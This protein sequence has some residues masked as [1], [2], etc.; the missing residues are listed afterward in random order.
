M[1][2]RS[3][4]WQIQSSFFLFL[5]W[6]GPK[7]F[8]MKSFLFARAPKKSTK[9]F[10]FF[11]RG[12]GGIEKFSR[13][14]KTFLICFVLTSNSS[15]KK[16]PHFLIFREGERGNK[17]FNIFQFGLFI[18]L[19]VFLGGEGGGRRRIQKS[20]FLITFSFCSHV[21]KFSVF[22]HFFHCFWREEEFKFLKWK[23]FLLLTHPK[24]SQHFPFFWER[25]VGKGEESE[26]FQD[27]WLFILFSRPTVQ[28]KKPFFTFFSIKERRNTNLPLDQSHILQLWSWI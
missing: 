12:G 2:F 3:K 25:G 24:I 26:N 1:N 8:G 17:C 13:L 14:M 18:F 20:S 11:V 6:G 19:G 5:F 28:W 27:Q 15:V 9:I 4:Q 23:P 16:N 10:Q 7:N 22:S 21:Q